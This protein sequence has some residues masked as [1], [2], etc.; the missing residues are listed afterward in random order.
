MSEDLALRAS[1]ADR[2]RTVATL[3]DATAAGRLSADELEERLEVAFASHYRSQLAELVA[4]LP[5]EA[6]VT[7][8]AGGAA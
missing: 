3:R 2:E 8:T 1:D 4:D 5:V 6:P 7:A